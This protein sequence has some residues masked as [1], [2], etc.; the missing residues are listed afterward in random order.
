MWAGRREGEES[1]S[2]MCLCGDL[3]ASELW[4]VEHYFV[5]NERQEGF[6][7]VDLLCGH[8]GAVIVGGFVCELGLLLVRIRDLRGLLLGFWVLGF[9]MWKV[10]VVYR[11]S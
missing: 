6:V 4:S 8:D 11:G 9:K 1:V 2:G 5:E 3:F 7:S 10:R